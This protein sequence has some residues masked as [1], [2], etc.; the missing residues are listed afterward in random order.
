M[1]GLYFPQKKVCAHCKQFF[2]NILEYGDEFICS[3]CY[4]KESVE[5]YKNKPKVECIDCKGFFGHLEYTITD[6]PCSKIRCW[7]CHEKFQKSQPKKK[8]V[9]CGDLVGYREYITTD[10]TFTKFRC[11]NCYD[12][13][14]GFHKTKN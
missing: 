12:E 10:S 13:R 4:R 5:Y 3:D 6:W 14:S 1:R 8:C 9:D 7:D 11:W 2:H